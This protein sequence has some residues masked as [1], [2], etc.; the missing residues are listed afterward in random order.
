M[1]GFFYLISVKQITRS[2]EDTP[3]LPAVAELRAVLD[4]AGGQPADGQGL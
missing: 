4:D 1:P 2:P 3:F